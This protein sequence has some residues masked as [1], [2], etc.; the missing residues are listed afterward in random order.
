MSALGRAP[1]VLALLLAG[2]ASPGERAPALVPPHEARSSLDLYALADPHPPHFKLPD[3]LSEISGL[4]MSA[5]DRLFAHDDERAVVYQLDYRTGAVVKWFALGRRPVRDDFEGVAIV[6]ARFFLVT[7]AG[8]LYET[9]EGAPGA[10]MPYTRYPTGLGRL[11]EVEGLAYDPAGRRLLLPCKRAL[12]RELAGRLSI[13]AVPLSSMRLEDRPRFALPLTALGRLVGRDGFHPSSIERN[14]RTG[15]FFVLSATEPALIEISATG[16][17][18]G[19]RRLPPAAHPQPE[20]VTVT[21]SGTLVI[22]DEARRGPA[23]LTLYAAAAWP[24]SSSS[25]AN[26]EARR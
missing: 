25:G 15:S 9:R 4:A 5:D 1:A 19:G 13:F 14:P 10:A 17:V 2:G 18:L 16:A 8:M 20:G 23:R 21:R 6:G 26:G 3:A 12:V 7:S 11:C 22:S 24:Q